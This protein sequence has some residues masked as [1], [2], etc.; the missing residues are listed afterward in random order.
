MVKSWGVSKSVGCLGSDS[1]SAFTSSVIWAK[2]RSSYLS[3]PRLLISNIGVTMMMMMMM[4]VMMM[5]MMVVVVMIMVTM[6]M[7]MIPS[8]MSLLF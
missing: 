7:M 4:G 2:Q 8:L 1:D 6:V 3:E 5:M